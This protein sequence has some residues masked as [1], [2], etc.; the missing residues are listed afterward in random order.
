ME[1][2]IG[3]FYQQNIFQNYKIVWYS[4][5]SGMIGKIYDNLFIR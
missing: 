3:I 1:K 5:I 4:T 2:L